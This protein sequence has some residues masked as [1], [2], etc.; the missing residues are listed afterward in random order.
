MARRVLKELTTHA[1]PLHPSRT[2]HARQSHLPFVDR[3]RAGGLFRRRCS[4]PDTAPAPAAPAAPEPDW[5]FNANIGLFSQYVFRGISQTNEKPAV[6][7]GFDYRPQERL[8]RRH[9]GVEHQLD[10]RRHSPTRRAASNGI[11]TAATNAS[12][13][14]RLQRRRRRALVLLPGQL[15]ARRRPRPTPPR[16]TP[17]SAG[18]CMSVEV[19]LRR[20]EQDVRRPRFGRQ[21]LHRRQRYRTTSSTRS[22]TCI[23]KITLIGHVGHQR[24][25]E[26]QRL[27]LHRLEGRRDAGRVA[28][29]RSASS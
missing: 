19:Q 17:R 20:R 3:R 18:S 24:Y 10:L 15:S 23:G 25:H 5:T 12:M 21:R 7:G 26:C 13:P 6:Q 27:Q 29:S 4:G 16:S 8:L 11:S 9:L 28:A 2:F 1:P 22:T 14:Q